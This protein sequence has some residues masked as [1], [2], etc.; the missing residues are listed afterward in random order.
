MHATIGTSFSYQNCNTVLVLDRFV[1]LTLA[2]ASLV[3]LISFF[4]D[5]KRTYRSLIVSA[6]VLTLSTVSAYYLY[7]PRAERA[8]KKAPILLE[9]LR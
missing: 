1:T 5:L 2:G 9:S 4:Y 3:L 8:I 7:A 6:L